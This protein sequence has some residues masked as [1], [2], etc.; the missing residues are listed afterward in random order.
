MI[1]TKTLD[2]I[3][4]YAQAF[5]ERIDGLSEKDKIVK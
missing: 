3:T 5:W 4:V 2:E 1:K